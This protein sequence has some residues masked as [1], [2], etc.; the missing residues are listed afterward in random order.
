MMP[1]ALYLLVCIIGYT[2]L[3]FIPTH[4][5]LLRLFGRKAAPA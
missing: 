2:L 3:V 1:P 4:L 5:V